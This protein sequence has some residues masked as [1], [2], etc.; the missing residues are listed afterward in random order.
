MQDQPVAKHLVAI[1]PLVF[2][3]LGSICGGDAR[4]QEVVNPSFETPSAA[5]ASDGILVDPTSTTQIGWT[6][7]QL[8]QKT[9][10]SGVQQNGSAFGGPS[11]PDKS[12]TAF[13]IN[14]GTITQTRTNRRGL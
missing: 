5:Q 12:Q 11:A 2:L 8:P 1:V 3:L 9:G 14:L 7:S 10:S 13:I 4:T 6:S